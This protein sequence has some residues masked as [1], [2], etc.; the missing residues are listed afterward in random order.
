MP[1]SQLEPELE[2]LEA[3]MPSE[4]AEESVRHLVK[5]VLV[6]NA[7][8]KSRNDTSPANARH[9]T[10]LGWEVAGSDLLDLHSPCL[11]Q[12]PQSVA[13]IAMGVSTMHVKLGEMYG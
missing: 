1:G 10:K 8:L 12:G 2:L 7:L 11:R 6:T 9:D 13:F 5:L 3:V 4:F